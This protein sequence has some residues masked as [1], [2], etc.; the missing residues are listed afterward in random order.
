MKIKSAFLLALLSNLPLF[1]AKS[2]D[3]KLVFDASIKTDMRELPLLVIDPTPRHLSIQ[4][5]KASVKIDLKTGDVQIPKD[6]TMDAT[7]IEFWKTVA[8]CFPEARRQIIESEKEKA[9]L[10]K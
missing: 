6:T 9:D 10:K 5:G 2:E 3:K 7:E 1:M 8:K 4:C